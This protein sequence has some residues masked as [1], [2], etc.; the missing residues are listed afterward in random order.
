MGLV[1][2]SDLEAAR[3]ATGERGEGAPFGTAEEGSK[4]ESDETRM[5]SPA[6]GAGL[7]G[8]EDRAGVAGNEAY[9]ALTE[10]SRGFLE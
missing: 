1:K 10:P 6:R 2:A 5:V 8:V 9:R 7:A 3:R 4:D